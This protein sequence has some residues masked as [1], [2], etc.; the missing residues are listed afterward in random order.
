MDDL[1]NLKNPIQLNRIPQN[2]MVMIPKVIVG[3][4]PNVTIHSTAEC[5]RVPC[6]HRLMS[7]YYMEMMAFQ[8]CKHV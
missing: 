6:Y 1:K 4:K 8:G 7:R 3:P 5:F 2:S